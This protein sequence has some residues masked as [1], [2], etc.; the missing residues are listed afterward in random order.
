MVLKKDSFTCKG[1]NAPTLG[2]GPYEPKGHGLRDLYLGTTKQCYT[3]N[4]EELACGFQED[5][6]V[7]LLYVY[8]HQGGPFFTLGA[9]LAGF[10]KL[11]IHPEDQTAN[12][13]VN[14]CRS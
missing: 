4:I 8:G 7:F 2:Y 11:E 13:V 9:W 12:Y 14:H 10:D 5:F 1:A 6:Y 3:Q